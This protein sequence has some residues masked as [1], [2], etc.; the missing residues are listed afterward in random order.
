MTRFSIGDKVTLSAPC[1]KVQT[2]PQK[3]QI[4]TVTHVGSWNVYYVK[5]NGIAHSIG[6]RG[7]ELELIKSTERSQS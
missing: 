3:Y 5:W 6:M 7:D 4:G 2:E 1:R